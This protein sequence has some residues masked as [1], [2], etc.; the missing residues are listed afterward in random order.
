MTIR[1]TFFSNISAII[2]IL[3]MEEGYGVDLYNRDPNDINLHLQ[4]SWTDLVAEPDEIRSADFVWKTSQKLFQ[5]SRRCC[6]Y[7]L[8]VIFF[9]PIS[10]CIGC[11]F[12]CLSFQHIWCVRPCVR[13]LKINCHAV[14]KIMSLCCDTLIG[15]FFEAVGL[16]FSR[17]KLVFTSTKQTKKVF[18]GA[19]SAAVESM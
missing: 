12:A 4:V 14:R 19:S 10:V 15:P 5:R 11:R 6:Y 3:P 18:T 17:F 16:V 2:G 9:V 7:V 8:T 13:D 1:L